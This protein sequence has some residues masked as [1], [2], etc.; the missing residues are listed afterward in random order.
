MGLALLN[1]N[2]FSKKQK[3]ITPSSKDCTTPFLLFLTTLTWGS[4]QKWLQEKRHGNFVA[5]CWKLQALVWGASVS[6]SGERCCV[7]P[8][9]QLMS[10]THKQMGLYSVTNNWTANNLFLLYLKHINTVFCQ[11][12][13]QESPFVS[14][15]HNV[16]RFAAV[17]EAIP[18]PNWFKRVSICYKDIPFWFPRYILKIAK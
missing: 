7:A 1:C 16:F 12:Q 14:F 15:V 5:Q 10:A 13:S 11:F 18:L 9:L 6:H 17:V 4:L 2:I 3:T 8:P